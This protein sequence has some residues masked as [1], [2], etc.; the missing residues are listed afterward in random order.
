MSP[1]CHFNSIPHQQNP[2]FI[3]IGSILILRVVTY[4]YRIPAIPVNTNYNSHTK[5]KA[6][7]SLLLNKDV[8][9]IEVKNTWLT[10]SK[11]DEELPICIRWLKSI[12]S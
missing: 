11:N 6:W 9:D 3:S 2:V 12:S 4:T 5:V 8:S 7:K 10:E 1:P